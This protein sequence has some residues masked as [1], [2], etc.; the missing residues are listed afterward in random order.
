MSAGV[1]A[2]GQTAPQSRLYQLECQSEAAIGI[3][4]AGFG[5]LENELPGDVVALLDGRPG[6]D[7]YG[8]RFF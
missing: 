3:H 1:I 8:A 5:K 4:Q 2:D 7:E 6:L